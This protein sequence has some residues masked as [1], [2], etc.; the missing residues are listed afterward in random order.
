MNPATDNSGNR[1]SDEDTFLPLLIALIVTLVLAPLAKPLPLVTVLAG[2]LAQLAGLYAVRHDRAFRATVFGGLILCLPLRLAEQIAGN[3]HPVLILLSHATTG[4]YFALLCVVVVRVIA[5][6]RVTS[7]TVIGAIC[8]YLLRSHGTRKPVSR[9]GAVFAEVGENGIG[10]F[11][12]IS[13]SLR[14]NPFFQHRWRRLRLPK[15]SRLQKVGTMSLF[16]AS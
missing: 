13:A 3:L 5:Q 16:H 9:R 11:S 4:A 2:F 14:E 8:G 10:H 15:S 7:Q 6:Q 1:G 12:A